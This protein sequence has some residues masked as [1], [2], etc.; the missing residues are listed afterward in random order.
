MFWSAGPLCLIEISSSYKP[1][2]FGVKVNVVDSDWPMSIDKG[3]SN[4]IE[5]TSVFIITS[6]IIKFADPEFWRLIWV[7]WTS[8]IGI[9]P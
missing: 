7:V 8:V 3:K 1:L 2:T 6:S 5:K 9:L 4:G